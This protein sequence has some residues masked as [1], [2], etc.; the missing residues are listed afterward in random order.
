MDENT[1]NGFT[2]EMEKL[3]LVGAL[4][5]GGAAVAGAGALGYGAYQSHKKDK[6]IKKK[7]QMD[8]LHSNRLGKLA[9]RMDPNQL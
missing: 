3:S 9:P 5:A 8:Q 1:R 4:L 6:A 7:R 2:S